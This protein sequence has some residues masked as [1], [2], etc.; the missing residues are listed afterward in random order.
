[1]DRLQW[2]RVHREQFLE[3]LDV[4]LGD[5]EITPTFTR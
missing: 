3:A 1:M 2:P 5:N 4:G